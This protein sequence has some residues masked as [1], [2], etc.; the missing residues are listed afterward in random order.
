MVLPSDH[1]APLF[2]SIQRF[3]LPICA[4]AGVVFGLS[5]PPIGLWVFALMAPGVLFLCLKDADTS[6]RFLCSTIFFTLAW[7]VAFHWNALHPVPTTAFSSVIALFTM[8]CL[9]SALITIFSTARKNSTPWISSSSSSSSSSGKNGMKSGAHFLWGALGIAMWDWIM[10]FG[11]MPMPGTMLG[12]SVSNSMLADGWAPLLGTYALTLIVL[13]VNVGWVVA[14]QQKA[15]RRWAVL[16]ILAVIFVPLLFAPKTIKPESSIQITSIQPGATPNEWADVNDQS[17][18]ETF[19]VLI[20]AALLDFPETEMVILPETA[21]PVSNS[22]TLI[23]VLQ[24]WASDF[25]VNIMAGGIE[26]DNQGQFYNVFAGAGAGASAG[27]GA[28][29][30]AGADTGPEA[31]LYQKRRL[32]PFVESVPFGDKLPFNDRFLLESGGVS[33][34]ESGNELVPYIYAGLNL[35]VLICFE[36]FFPSDARKLKKMGA[37]ILIVPTQDGWWGSQTARAQHASYSRMIALAVGMSVVQSSVDGMTVMWD[38]TGR[39]LAESEGN[40]LEYVNATFNLATRCT[41][42]SFSG[43]YPSNVFLAILLIV[44]L[45]G[46]SRSR[47]A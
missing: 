23:N 36:S 15:Y 47:R 1:S 24:K 3:R 21:L 2:Q 8:I 11:P 44:Y 19:G 17:K 40:G 14:L 28:G 33:S 37:E 6:T 34:Y 38:E 43:D 5:W 32:I 41:V 4:V 10:M 45:V 26:V 42:Y 25:E 9:Q 16:V 12:L 13:F 29:S 22:D 46:L 27:R 39:V 18:I 31:F 20:A 35:G 30:N 7:S